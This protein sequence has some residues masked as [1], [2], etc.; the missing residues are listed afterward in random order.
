[1]PL[2][3]GTYV[4][5]TGIPTCSQRCW[6]AVLHAWPAALA[7][8]HALPH[9]PVEGPIDVAVAWERR[10]STRSGIRVHR[11]RH[12]DFLVQQHASPP[13]V[14]VEPAALLVAASA[15]SDLDAI[16]AVTSVVGAR[17]TTADRLEA[18]LGALPR[19]RRRRLLTRLVDDLAAGTHSVLE[20]GFLTQ[21]V[22]PHGLPAVR[23]Q[24]YGTP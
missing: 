17:W 3:P 24:V 6:A 19:L 18:S 7:L 11:T 5:H 15:A 20:H 22:R 13:R 10:V 8:R 14:R 12:W 23:Q 16:A 21:V 4:T 9:P 1:M 2:H